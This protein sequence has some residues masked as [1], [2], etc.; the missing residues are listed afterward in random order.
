MR[1]QYHSMSVNGRTLIW[2]V[3]RLVEL[4]RAYP[5]QQVPL[6]QIRE[7]DECFWFQGE[8]ATCRAVALHAKLIQQV[9]PAYPIILSA[10]GRVMDGMHRVCK[11]LLEN[12][13]ALPA[14]Q[15]V[16]DPEPD[17]IDADVDALP[18]HEPG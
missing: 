11:A 7:L 13:A 9:D 17:Y 5:V 14:V 15:F 16:E 18:Y 8:P 12:K 3:H 1:R 4:T 2:D 10:S 6:S